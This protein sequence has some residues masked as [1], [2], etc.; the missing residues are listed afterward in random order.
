VV[1]VHCPSE[2]IAKLVAGESDGKLRQIT[3]S[4]Q[5]DLQDTFHNYVRIKIVLQWPQE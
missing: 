1:L 4:L 2:R 3:E 5:K